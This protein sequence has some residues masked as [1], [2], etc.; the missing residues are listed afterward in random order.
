MV[1]SQSSILFF[2]NDLGNLTGVGRA[3]SFFLAAL[4]IMVTSMVK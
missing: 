1:I 3:L 4:M 2:Y